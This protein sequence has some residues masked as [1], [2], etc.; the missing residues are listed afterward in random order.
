[1]AEM[2]GIAA[3]AR[4][5]ENKTGLTGRYDF[6]LDCMFD[7]KA[8]PPV[9]GDIADGPSCFDAIE[10]Q[11]GLRRMDTKEPME[12]LGASTNRPRTS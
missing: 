4:I 12:M 7:D 3:D 10:Q 5:V 9:A 2:G 11:L 1:M 8:G 6:T